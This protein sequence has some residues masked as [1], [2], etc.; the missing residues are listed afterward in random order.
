MSAD[1]AQRWLDDQEAL[2]EDVQTCDI[3]E[4]S[5]SMPALLFNLFE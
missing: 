4:P 1:C 5:S 2:W 3:T